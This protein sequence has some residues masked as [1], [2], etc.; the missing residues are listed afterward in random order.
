MMQ[1]KTVV[2]SLIGLG[3]FASGFA[4]GQDNGLWQR[5]PNLAQAEQSCHQADQ[6]LLNAQHA[7][8]WDLHGH[9]AKAEQMLRDADREIWAAARDSDHR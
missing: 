2:A 8:H 3:L 4:I 5:H 1:R 9:A 7:N 6:Y